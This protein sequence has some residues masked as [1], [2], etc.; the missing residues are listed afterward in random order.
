MH[1][2]TIKK[3]KDISEGLRVEGAGYHEVKAAQSIMQAAVSLE[4]A[5]AARAPK[6]VDEVPATP[7]PAPQVE[8]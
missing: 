1:E 8:P 6:P 5:D 7:P 4:D 2:E 3:L